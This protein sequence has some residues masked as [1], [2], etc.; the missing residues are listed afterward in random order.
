MTAEIS[1]S[2]G[3]GAGQRA[4]ITGVPQGV[5]A[6]AGARPATEP[7]VTEPGAAA[8]EGQ[9]AGPALAPADEAARAIEAARRLLA[10]AAAAIASGDDARLVEGLD[11]AASFT[12]HIA[13][14]L[15]FLRRAEREAARE[16]ER[17]GM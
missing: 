4:H 5:P 2:A 1:G 11:L 9:E 7:G 15:W 6:A 10:E 13:R 16:G 3:Q 14:A 12:D 17:R 8:P